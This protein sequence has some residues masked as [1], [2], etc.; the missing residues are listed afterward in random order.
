M[1]FSFCKRQIWLELAR[2]TQN[3]ISL[4]SS[5]RLKASSLKF[6]AENR[7]RSGLEVYFAYKNG[8]VNAFLI[9]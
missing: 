3:I 7:A 9:L 8:C 6:R 1:L 2:E 5:K 4:I